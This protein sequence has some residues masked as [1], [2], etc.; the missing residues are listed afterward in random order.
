VHL[1][2]LDDAGSAKN[3]KERYLVLG[4]VAV[5]EAQ[6]H[7]ITREMDNL[8]VSIDAANANAIEFHASEIF[9]GR[10]SP[11]DQMNREQRR[12]TIRNVLR[13]LSGAYDSCCA[14]SCA[15]HKASFPNVDPI[16]DSFDLAF[17]EPPQ[18]TPRD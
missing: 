16:P 17:S 6:A 10:S 5:F 3:P 9:S 11:W 13:V 2:Y 4:G 15:I 14:F 7:W 18:V 8:A 1:L 12:E